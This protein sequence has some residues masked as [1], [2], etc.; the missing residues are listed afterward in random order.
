METYAVIAYSQGCLFYDV[1]DER[2]EAVEYADRSWNQM[3]DQEKAS[4]RFFLVAK[5]ELYDN[6]DIDIHTAKP[7]KNYN[8][9]KIWKR[10]FIKNKIN[11]LL[12]FFKGKGQKWMF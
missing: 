1:F 4:Y 5:V 8:T 6:G 9:A 10:V 2:I 11:K 12:T 3:C 7:I